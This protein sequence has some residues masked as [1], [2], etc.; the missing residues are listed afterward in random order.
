MKTPA[1]WDELT[2][3]EKRSAQREKNTKERLTK[4]KK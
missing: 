3:S 4:Y 2:P 1:N